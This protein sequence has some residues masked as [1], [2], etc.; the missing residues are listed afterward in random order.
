[1]L[2]KPFGNTNPQLSTSS[3]RI[4][5]KYGGMQ[6]GKYRRRKHYTQLAGRSEGNKKFWRREMK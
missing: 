5:K 1:M 2:F 3:R 6:V 4:K